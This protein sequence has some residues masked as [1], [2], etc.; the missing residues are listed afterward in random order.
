ML[1]VYAVHLV[2]DEAPSLNFDRSVLLI[3]EQCHTDCEFPNLETEKMEREVFIKILA[4]EGFE[5]TVTV[6]R[7]PGGFLELHAHPF[8]AKAL[9]LKGELV[10]NVQ[11]AEQCY[12]AGQVFHLPAGTP[13]LEQYGPQGVEYL[14]GRR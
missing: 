5:E 7:E 6:M 14:V 3:K 1:D 4:I 9:I 8:E 11:G 12:R 10:L 13:H 2:P